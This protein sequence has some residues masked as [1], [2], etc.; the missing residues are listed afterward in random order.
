MITQ[1][2]KG[3]KN[4]INVSNDEFLAKAIYLPSDEREQRKLSEFIALL[5]REIVVETTRLEILMKL[6]SGYLQKMFY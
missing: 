5:D 2:R 3:A 1:V 4:T 6:R